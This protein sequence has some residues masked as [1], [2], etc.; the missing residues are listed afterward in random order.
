MT[1]KKFWRFYLSRSSKTDKKFSVTIDKGEGKRTKT[2]HFGQKTA[3]DYTIHKD[4][5][6]MKRYVKRHR[7]RENWKISG[8]ETAGFWSRWLLWNKPSFRASLT[9]IRNKFGIKIVNQV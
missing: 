5:E 2:I 3:S 8:V 6:R 9:D 7:A 4:E 1:N